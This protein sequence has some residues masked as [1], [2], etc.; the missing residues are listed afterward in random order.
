MRYDTIFLIPKN[1][2]RLPSGLCVRCLADDPKE[3]EELGST[4]IRVPVCSACDEDNRRLI[5]LEQSLR[6]A[7]YIAGAVRFVVAL[8]ASAVL[9]PLLPKLESGSVEIV[10]VGALFPLVYWLGRFITISPSL[11]EHR[12]VSE[13]AMGWSQPEA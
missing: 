2:A 4:G 8:L 1:S 3:S 7:K 6:V 10:Y 9:Y 13:G 12:T 5:R 11:A